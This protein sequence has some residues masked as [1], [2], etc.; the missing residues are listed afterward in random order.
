MQQAFLD[1]LS[2]KL[3]FNPGD[4]SAFYS[5][6]SKALLDHG[7]R[8]LLS[9][10]NQSIFEMLRFVYPHFQWDPLRF[11]RAPRN[12]W[13][14][15]A[16]QRAF[17]DALGQKLGFKE[18]D[19]ERWYTVTTKILIENGGNSIL[20]RHGQSVAALLAAVYPEVKWDPRRFAK[21]P[22]IFLDTVANQRAALLD[23][24]REMGIEEGDWEAWYQV[25][26]QRLIEHGG[27]ALL[28]RY[29]Q[30]LYGLL[31]SL[32]PEF[33]WDRLKFSKAPQNYWNS[34]DNRKGFLDEMGRSLG[35][36]KDNMERWYEVTHKDVHDLGGGALLAQFH[37]SLPNM[38]TSIYSNIKWD[39]IKFHKTPGKWKAMENQRAFLEALACKL[40]WKEGDMEAFYQLTAKILVAEG[41]ESLLRQYGDSVFALVS[42]VYPNHEWNPWRFPLRVGQTSEDSLPLL[43]SHVED[44]LKVKSPQDWYRIS[45]QDLDE[46]GVGRVLR[47]LDGGLLGALKKR[48]P[49]ETWDENALTP[50][51]KRSRK[52]NSTAL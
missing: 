33:K 41:G 6:T 49:K 37:G 27:G 9:R 28:L 3:G 15:P 35:I 40:G 38:I 1:D 5:L 23:I 25:T 47:A 32:I 51:K 42:A 14:S 43:F 34:F 44:S 36:S 39:P 46:L 2:T 7:G 13:S 16:N 8:G 19:F 26:S 18:R 21:T 30:S 48:Y 12:Y 24:G 50:V 10:Y 29:E 45:M 11:D 22:K 20:K 31:S 4:L 17:M 52:V